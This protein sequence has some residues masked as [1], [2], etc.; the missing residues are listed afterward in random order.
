MLHDARPRAL[1]ELAL[2]PG[3]EAQR[4]ERVHER[5]AVREAAHAQRRSAAATEAVRNEHARGSE[6][7]RPSPN[8]GARERVS[9]IGARGRAHNPFWISIVSVGRSATNDSTRVGVVSVG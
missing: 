1:D 6:D 4:R 9:G 5:R 3:Q 7:T 8:R 2:R